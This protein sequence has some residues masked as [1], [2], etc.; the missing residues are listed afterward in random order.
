MWVSCAWMCVFSCVTVYSLTVVRKTVWTPP[1]AASVTREWFLSLTSRWSILSSTLSLLPAVSAIRHVTEVGLA[2]ARS[3][4][5]C[6]LA[7]LSIGSGCPSSRLLFIVL[8]ALTQRESGPAHLLSVT[9]LIALPSLFLRSPVS[10]ALWRQTNVEGWR[11]KW[12]MNGRMFEKPSESS[13]SFR[14]QNDCS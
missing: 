5:W 1:T 7:N 6:S 8:L 10:P 3:K 2:E 9:L 12:E 4:N 13:V 11:R 14:E